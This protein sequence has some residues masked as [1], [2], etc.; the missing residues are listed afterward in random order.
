MG[1]NIVGFYD[2]PLIPVVFEPDVEA[3][4]VNE[5]EVVRI[6]GMKVVTRAILNWSRKA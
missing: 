3:T 2:L 6:R 5:M 4:S 1:K